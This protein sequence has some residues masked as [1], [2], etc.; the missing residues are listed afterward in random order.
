MK[1]KKKIPGK[2]ADMNHVEE[3]KAFIK[4]K[5]AEN[6]VLEKLLKKIKTNQ[7]GKIKN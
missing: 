5:K 6:K 2:E 3:M 7:S 4:R 1:S